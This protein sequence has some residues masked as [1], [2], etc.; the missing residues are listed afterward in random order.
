MLII[1]V[2]EKDVLLGR[3]DGVRKR[4]SHPLCLS[5][6]LLRKKQGHCVWL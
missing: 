1:N 2:G 5:V 6:P 3:K 4:F